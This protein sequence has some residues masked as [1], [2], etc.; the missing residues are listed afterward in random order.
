MLMKQR[1]LKYQILRYYKLVST[2]R[3]VAQ[4]QEGPCE[5]E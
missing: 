2:E 1:M 5:L 3:S 4:G